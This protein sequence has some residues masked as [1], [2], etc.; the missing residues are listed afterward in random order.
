[1]PMTHQSVK[2]L[3]KRSDHKGWSPRPEF[4]PLQTVMLGKFPLTSLSLRSYTREVA[5]WD[6]PPCWAEGRGKGQV[7]ALYNAD[8]DLLTTILTVKS[9]SL[10]PVP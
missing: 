2:S 8:L 10:G 9:L 6:H 3:G 5:S 1:M 4:K 7:G